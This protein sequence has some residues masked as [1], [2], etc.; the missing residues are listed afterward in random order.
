MGS[1][2][3]YTRNWP[4]VYTN[5]DIFDSDGSISYDEAIQG[6]LGSCYVIASLG[7]MGEFPDHVRNLFVTK[8]KNDVKAHAVRFYIRGKP[9]VVTVNEEL[10]FMY[11][12]PRLKFA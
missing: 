10:L 12:N 11:S 1:G 4:D 8:N 5:A 9:W 6:G 7:S 2:T 3:Y